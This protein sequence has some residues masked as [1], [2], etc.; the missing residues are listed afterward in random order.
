MELKLVEV[1]EDEFLEDEEET[2]AAGALAKE[3]ENFGRE[4]EISQLLLLG[5]AQE[6]LHSTH[7]LKLSRQLNN[8]MMDTE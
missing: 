2:V 6:I 7:T 8:A 5:E 3:V 1:G 4:R